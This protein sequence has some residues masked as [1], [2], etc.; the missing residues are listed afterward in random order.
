MKKHHITECVPLKPAKITPVI[1][2][3][4]RGLLSTIDFK[5]HRKDVYI[6][7][8]KNGCNSAY[9]SGHSLSFDTEFY[10][11]VKRDVNKRVISAKA[12]VYIWQACID[13]H[14]FL[15]RD[16]NAFPDFCKE[17][18]EIFSLD[19]KHIMTMLI[20]NSG[21][22][23]Q[24][25]KNITVIKE[26]FL[27]SMR[28]PLTFTLYNGGIEILDACRISGG[29]LKSIGKDFC[30]TKKLTGD[31]DYTLPR[32]SETPLTE[33]E[34]EY[35]INDVVIL[36]EYY[37]VLYNMYI[38]NGYSIPKTQTS[39]LRKAVHE[40]YYENLA[41]RKYWNITINQEEY[42]NIRYWAYRGGFT[43]ANIRHIDIVHHNVRG[44]DLTSSYPAVMM[45]KTFP[46]SSPRAWHGTL[47]SLVEYS[48]NKDISWYGCFKFRGLR[49]TTD[50]SIES[51][52]KTVE[53]NECKDV[54]MMCNNLDMVYDN[55]RIR[56]IGDDRWITVWL[57]NI[58]Y[59]LYTKFYTW[60]G[61]AYRHLMFMN[62]S[63][64]PDYLLS[65]LKH[66]YI[67]KCTLKKEG[68][69]D[70]PE[71]V[72]AKKIVNS[73]YGLCC[74]K[75]ADTVTMYSTDKG[76]TETEKKY[77]EHDILPVMWGVWITAYARQTLLDMVYSIGNDVLY[78]D[79][80][81][82]YMLN[83]EQH[84]NKILQFNEQIMNFNK[85][86]GNDL[87]NDLGCFELIDE[88]GTT[89]FE[90]FKTLGAKRY[91]K[92]AGGVDITTIAG[93]PKQ[94]LSEYCKQKELDIY[95]IFN[96]CMEIPI[97]H[98]FKNTTSYNDTPHTELITDYLGNTMEMHSES[99]MGIYSITFNMT[100]NE[101]YKK[102]IDIVNKQ[103]NLP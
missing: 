33:N 62:N 90:K 74:Q 66:F 28:E 93:L 70:T 19:D 52:S 98:T 14:V 32:H 41:N 97:E 87:F 37:D 60:N 25:I 103:N 27:M 9:Y 11:N 94:A 40:L 12:Y 68:K 38:K 5:E 43:H 89:V 73:G 63:L 45:R 82:I 20:A 96:D 8:G 22:E 35:C 56:S 79:T 26:C 53:Y 51:V 7:R 15:C 48:R 54:Y 86:L 58:D 36:S 80:D 50:H 30:V 65:P 42:E 10:T 67:R 39:V 29:S 102:S 21:C 71:Y 4:Y 16:L 92:T 95:D 64:L 69:K 55:G 31:L 61:I 23:Y 3:Y 57:T 101:L 24:Y 34:L 47:E 75:K 1:H 49:A 100:M 91:L 81:S 99:S 2:W 77:I 78:C 59:D 6:H 18:I 83:Y 84:G 85:S 46:C 76:F 13:E 72:N 44:I 88:N 17:V